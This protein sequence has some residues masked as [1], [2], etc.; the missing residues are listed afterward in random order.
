MSTL[1]AGDWVD[2]RSKDEILS[3]LDKNGRLDELPFMPQ[4]FQYCGK[5]F[6]V[7]KRAHKTC[8]TIAYNW[9]SPGRSVPNGIHLNL[10]CDGQAYGGCQAACLIFWKEDWLKP[11]TGA[12]GETWVPSSAGDTDYHQNG[13][14]GACTEEDVTRG[15]RAKGSNSRDDAIYDCQATR[16]LDYTKPLPWWDARQY[17]EDYTSGNASLWRIVRGFVYVGYYY[18]TL[19]K[20]RR[21]GGPARWFYDL[22][23]SSWG[24]IP[25]PRRT[26]ELPEG[27]I[28]PM[29]TLNLKPGEFV[30][31]KS[32][33]EILKTMDNSNKNRGMGFDGELVPYCG[34]TFRVRGRVEKFI[35][36]KTGKMRTMKT[37]AVILD[38]VI[39]NSRYSGHR[40]FCPRGIFAWWREV[41]LERVSQEEKP[42]TGD[43]I[44]VPVPLHIEESP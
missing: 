12:E 8:D 19:A 38:G 36:E 17:F 40:M 41:W 39:C 5:R 11:V 26:G 42:Q 15:T 21:F 1:R 43:V 7:Y 25:F 20:S 23:Q 34:R 13:G 9:D 32:Y 24:G 16:L 28:G 10:R 29:S 31:V 18:G 6:Q 35:D 4:M 33:S 30:R 3:T 2:V 37:P 22:V 27:A 14:N 44:K